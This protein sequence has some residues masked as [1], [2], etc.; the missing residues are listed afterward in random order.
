MGFS[1]NKIGH[2]LDPM[3]G[4]KGQTRRTT[5]LSKMVRPASPQ[6]TSN[7][8]GGGETWKKHAAVRNLGIAWLRNRFT[9]P[10]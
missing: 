8:Y 6:I 7:F 2:T 4:G 1:I 5:A 9:E 10:F 3:R